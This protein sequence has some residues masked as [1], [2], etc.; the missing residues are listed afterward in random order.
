MRVSLIS[1]THAK[2]G[3]NVLPKEIRSNRVLPDLVG[4]DLLIHAGEFMTSGYSKSEVLDFFTWLKEIEY[5]NIVF[6]AGN[7]DRLHKLF[8]TRWRSLSLDFPS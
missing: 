4:G 2:H 3:R 8:L 5:T 6:I 1:D 7:H